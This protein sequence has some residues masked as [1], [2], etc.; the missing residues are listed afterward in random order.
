MAGKGARSSPAVQHVHVIGAGVMGGD[1]AA[2]CALRGMNVTLQDRAAE[3]IEPAL[4]RAQEFFDKRLRDT[5]KSQAARQ[6]LRADVEGVGVEDADV[7]IEAIFENLEAKQQLYA[8]LEPRMKPAALLA[9]NTS[10][11]MLEPLSTRL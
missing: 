9:T 1:I 2:W 4:K 6:R 11:L 10:S 5:T 3:L 7:V 8:Q